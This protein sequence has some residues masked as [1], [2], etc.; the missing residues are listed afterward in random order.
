MKM[1]DRRVRRI[2]HIE[3]CSNNTKDQE[4]QAAD[5]DWA[6]YGEEAEEE[7][8]EEEAGPELFY[9]KDKPYVRFQGMECALPPIKGEPD[10]EWTISNDGSYWWVNAG[11]FKRRRIDAL[12]KCERARL[13]LSCAQQ[14]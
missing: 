13:L 8:E 2:E 6:D 4:E 3:F 12:M 14:S 7:D 11:K 5:S 9:I 1:N 10:V